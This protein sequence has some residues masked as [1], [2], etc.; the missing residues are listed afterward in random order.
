VNEYRKDFSGEGGG[1]GLRMGEWQL[2]FKQG[3]V[4]GE[5]GH[6]D[7]EVQDQVRVDES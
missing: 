7:G 2:V 1:E 6:L 4:C 5:E 3:Q